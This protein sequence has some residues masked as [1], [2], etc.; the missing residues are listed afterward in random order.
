LLGT[1]LNIKLELNS[2]SFIGGVTLLRA[3]AKNHARVTVLCDTSDYPKLIA[4]L[5]SSKD[6]TVPAEFRQQLALKAFTHTQEYD[7]AIS[8]YFRDT[9]SDKRQVL[10]L[11]Y[12]CNPHQKP[13]KVFVK[14]GELPFKGELIIFDK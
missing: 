12:G 13:A 8:G 4:S 6:L 9:Y 5:K 7:E 3:A 10:T 1:I 2:F 11:R 14:H